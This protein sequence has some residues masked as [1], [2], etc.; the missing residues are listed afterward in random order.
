MK[1]L[2]CISRTPD[3]TAKIAFTEGGTKFSEAHI[4]E[5]C[6]GEAMSKQNPHPI[7]KIVAILHRIFD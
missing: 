1:I 7:S 5:M 2:V 4:F 6:V 3:T